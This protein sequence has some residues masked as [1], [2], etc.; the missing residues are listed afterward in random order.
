MMMIMSTSNEYNY[1]EGEHDQLK[2]KEGRCSQYRDTY[3]KLQTDTSGRLTPLP[4]AHK[5]II[6]SMYTFALN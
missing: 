1:A 6:R 2:G 5:C 4:L 3:S